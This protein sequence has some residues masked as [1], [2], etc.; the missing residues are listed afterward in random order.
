MHEKCL[1]YIAPFCLAFL[2]AVSNVDTEFSII[3]FI[4]FVNSGSSK[5]KNGAVKPRANDKALSYDVAFDLTTIWFLVIGCFIVVAFL[6]AFT[7]LTFPVSASSSNICS[8]LRY[9]GRQ[10]I[11]SLT[12]WRFAL[13]FP[14]SLFTKMNVELFVPNE[15]AHV[16]AANIDSVLPCWRGRHNQESIPR[17]KHHICAMLPLLALNLTGTPPCDGILHIS[18]K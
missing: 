15:Y 11:W 17:T 2:D 5:C 10:S 18:L 16:Y 9:S 14:P 4:W 12:L 1:P 6:T 8:N 7:I 3:V 13:A